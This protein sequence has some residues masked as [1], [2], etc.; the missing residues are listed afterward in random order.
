M[1]KFNVI[2]RLHMYAGDTEACETPLPP[3]PSFLP[4]NN[5]NSHSQPHVMSCDTDSQREEMGGNSY[6]LVPALI[7]DSEEPEI[8]TVAPRGSLKLE[9]FFR[10]ENFIPPGLL[11]RIMSRTVFR[12]GNNVKERQQQALRKTGENESYLSVAK[13]YWKSSFLQTFASRKGEVSVWV[14]IEKEIERETNVSKQEHSTSNHDRVDNTQMV[15]THGTIRISVMGNVL[16]CQDLVKKLEFYSDIVWEMLNPHRALCHVSQAVVC[17]TCS[18]KERSFKN[19]GEFSPEDIL[20]L[21]EELSEISRKKAAHIPSTSTSQIDSFEWTARCR[22]RCSR[23]AC[24]VDPEHLTVIPTNLIE[25]SLHRTDLDRAQSTIN[26][27]QEEII[28]LSSKP[29]AAIMNSVCKV[30]VGFC[31]KKYLEE[32]RQSIANGSGEV[33]G[34]NLAFPSNPLLATGVVLNI[35]SADS[36][37]GNDADNLLGDDNFVVTCEHFIGDPVTKVSFLINNRGLE[38][39]FLIGGKA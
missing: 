30:G 18:I 36:P 12:Y 14:W 31:M 32:A 23:H 24:S 26:F 11:Q 16:L 22:R 35:Q 38:P 3:L 6:F 19:C 1:L 37:L 20:T 2:I 39:V 7:E 4:C 34:L 8:P 29:T 28:R 15:Q 13:N 5:E 21:N 10:L 9:A 25:D 33:S 27:L 17:P